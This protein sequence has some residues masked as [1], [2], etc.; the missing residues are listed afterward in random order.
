MPRWLRQWVYVQ[1]A[2]RGLCT[3]Q[4]ADLGHKEG[5]L[6]GAILALGLLRGAGIC[7]ENVGL[8]DPKGDTLE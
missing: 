4:Q 1:L 5:V 3:E 2:E 6:Q 8:E 7:R